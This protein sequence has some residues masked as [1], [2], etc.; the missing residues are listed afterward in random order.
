MG[1]CRQVDLLLVNIL[2]LLFVFGVMMQFAVGC[3]FRMHAL[4][5]T[6]ELGNVQTH[7]RFLLR[8]SFLDPTKIC[9]DSIVSRGTDLS[10]QPRMTQ[11]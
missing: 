8:V 4:L 7:K 9:R 10:L 5:R 3:E 6:V 1:P 2:G 11:T